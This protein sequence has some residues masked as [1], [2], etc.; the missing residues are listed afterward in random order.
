MVT[1]DHPQP[2]QSKPRRR[3]WLVV[4]CLTVIPLV[5]I[6]V[7][8][9]ADRSSR[10]PIRAGAP[11][12]AASHSLDPWRAALTTLHAQAAALVRRDEP[13]WLAAVDPA[14]AQTRGFFQ[15][16]FA[17][18]AALDVSQF[19]YQHGIP[20]VL[21]IGATRFVADIYSTYCFSLDRCPAFSLGTGMGSPKIKEKVT[22]RQVGD[23]WLISAAVIADTP[24]PLQPT[25]W[26]GGHLVVARGSRVTVAATTSNATRLSN[27]V[28]AADRAAAT[29][30]RFAVSIG[31]PQR[32]YRIYLAT[33]QQWRVWYGGERS[34]WASGYTIGLND[35]ESD[36]VLRMSRIGNATELANTL[37]H[38]LG[39]V[40]TLGGT[41]TGGKAIY[42]QDQWLDEGIAE[43]IA[44]WPRPANASSRRSAVRIIVHSTVRPTSIVLGELDDSASRRASD[45]YY[46]LSHFGVDCL[47]RKFGQRKLLEF[48]TLKLRH[49]NTYDQASRKAFGSP[50]RPIDTACVTWIRQHA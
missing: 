32:R 29:A 49:A 8:V 20:P 15:K 34:T 47:A 26:E 31:N 39:H 33:D 21:T 44:Y 7:I 27:V 46:G 13:G 42:N 3:L 16:R 1:S 19:S 9:V 24:D 28:V 36:V 40:V 25:P 5:L 11:I 50:F 43:Y 14:A 22:F 12:P 2:A 23:R 17:A 37:Q 4:G 18:L 35:V 38:E 10:A 6:A 30:D 41:D 48:V 45:A